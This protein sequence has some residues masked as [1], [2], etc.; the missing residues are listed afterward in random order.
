MRGFRFRARRAGFVHR[1]PLGD[2]RGLFLFRDQ[3]L[4]LAQDGGQE[5]PVLAHQGVD[6][7]GVVELAGNLDVGKARGADGI[8]GDGQVLHGRVGLAERHQ[9][10]GL[11]GVPGRDQPDVLAVLLQVLVGRAAA[12]G[13]HPLA[14]QTLQGIDRLVVPGQDRQGKTQVGPDEKRIIGPIRGFARAVDHVDALFA[15]RVED[16]LEIVVVADGLEL[17]GQARFPG[18]QREVVAE[19]PLLPAV[20]E[21]KQRPP[22]RVAVADDGVGLDEGL[23]RIGQVQAG[24]CGPGADGNRKRHRANREQHAPCTEEKRMPAGLHAHI[25]GRAWARWPRRL[26]LPPP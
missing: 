18:E 24:C 23:F 16:Q 20:L 8:G 19:K 9:G 26:L 5:R 1:Q 17:E 4:R 3:P 2:Q 22:V 21:N 14:G 7:E 10:Q 25:T 11:G 13:G 12:A 15:Q 6:L